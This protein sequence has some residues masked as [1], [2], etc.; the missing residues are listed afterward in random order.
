[1]LTLFFYI[2]AGMQLIKVIYMKISLDNATRARF[3]EMNTAYNTSS[4]NVNGSKNVPSRGAVIS[5]STEMNT[6]YEGRDGKSVTD[7]KNGAAAMDVT[8][9]Q[10]FMTVASNCLSA[11]D[12]SKICK[13]GKDMSDIDPA[14][15]VTIVDCMKLAMAKG[16]A[17]IHGYT[18][19]IDKETLEAMTGNT[20]Y[21]NSIF[22]DNKALVNDIS[23]Q[24]F[25][26][27]VTLS[28]DMWD[29]IKNVYDMNADIES[30]TDA[31]KVSFVLSD[32]ELTID[33]LYLAKHTSTGNA[34]VN[35]AAYFSIDN[36]GYLARKADSKNDLSEEI[37]TLLSD[38]GIE[39]TAENIENSKWLVE[40]SL[41]ID[42]QA[43]EKLDRLSNIELPLSDSA[44]AKEVVI[45]FSEGKEAK[46]A[47]VDR[48]ENLYEKAVRLTEEVP[49]SFKDEKAQDII[50]RLTDGS[51]DGIRSRRVLEQVR[52]SMTARV[53]LELLKSDFYIDTKD[54]ETVVDELARI[55]NDSAVTDAKAVYEVEETIKAINENPADIL[56]RF[57]LTAGL[58]IESLTLNEVLEASEEIGSRYEK[59]A[60]SYEALS[61]EV[62]RDLGDSIKKAFRNI[63]ELL[64]EQGIEVNEKN[65]RL[66]RILG[67]NSME[68]NSRNLE[69]VEEADDKLS[70]VLNR[71]TPSDT[72]DLIRKG[73][74][75]LKLS[76]DELNEYLDEKTDAKKEEI[77]KYSKFLY[78]LEKNDSITALERE[79]YISVYRLFGE[80]RRGDYQAIGALVN[81]NAELSLSNLK[82]AVKTKKHE[83]MDIKV[84]QSFGLLAASVEEAIEPERL[85]ACSF[86]E[87]TT[88]SEVYDRL[89]DTPV[90]NRY[91]AMY[92]EEKLNEYREGLKASSEAVNELDN[93]GE[94][95]TIEKLLASEA[96]TSK[97][98]RTL[99][100]V[101]DI[102]DGSVKRAGEKIRQSLMNR[103]EASEA[104]AEVTDE[105]EDM[106]FEEAVKTDTYVDVRE[107]ALMYKQMNLIRDYSYD[108][109]Y[110]V[111]MEIGGEE[112]L[113]N[114]K[115]IHSEEES[116][117]AI[118][119]AGEKFGA[120]NARF[121]VEEEKI[122][123]Y[124][125]TNLREAVEKLDK[126]S[127][128]I[129]E[130]ISVVYSEDQKASIKFSKIP[131]KDNSQKTD[132]SK[133]YKVAEDFLREIANV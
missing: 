92:Q 56:G 108:E 88:M 98:G 13:D 109:N 119:F 40:H 9:M 50:N 96:L 114:V 72:L 82:Q 77:E 117:V 10:N 115:M 112:I 16:G 104:I 1:M 26:Y 31:M 25:K 4:A 18:D 74:S 24:A 32:D 8:A 65:R 68:I 97:S 87:T 120:V 61:T 99:K 47:I 126:V 54:I 7:I 64:S 28:D 48:T 2:D 91:E 23:E 81:Q 85:K 49:K 102:A 73:S 94:T 52:L 41:C 86:N 29:D 53:N 75:P 80:L 131:L 113:V 101:N 37:M 17:D 57:S 76:V 78:K 58:S 130:G 116:S 90:D 79:E 125:S 60:L 67:Y 129:G 95:V 39:P 34:G 128:K 70:K 122:G 132:T 5:K 111:P 121:S 6:I 55:E 83:G 110:K 14:D 123:G 27:D 46:D 69:K 33:N 59:A 42:R 20:A 124:I 36:N 44:F 3:D 89:I 30:I 45:A 12:F 71:L 35:G 22:N 103:D 106:I 127:D 51:I 118:S 19:D 62:R 105:F 15:R 66:V 21:A 43:L 133:L 38:T 93:S 107:L 100:K 84:D 63:D 11:Q